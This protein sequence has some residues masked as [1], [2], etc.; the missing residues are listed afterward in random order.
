MY[1]EGQTHSVEVNLRER[2]R[3][4]PDLMAIGKEMPI[5]LIGVLFYQL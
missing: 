4:S 1:R 2:E 5:K 3:E